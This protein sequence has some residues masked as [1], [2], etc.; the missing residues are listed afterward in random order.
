MPKFNSVTNNMETAFSDAEEILENLKDELD[1]WLGSVQSTKLASGAKAEKVED[2]LGEVDDA[3]CELSE[4]DDL[5]NELFVH[6]PKIKYS[7]NQKPIISRK[8]KVRNAINILE[9]IL[10]AIE[11]GNSSLWEDVDDV[12]QGIENLTFTLHKLN[13]IEF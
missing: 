2:A 7:Q 5:I 13:N 1:E 4:I 6:F 8:D 3:L 10:E 11:N 9:A 12:T